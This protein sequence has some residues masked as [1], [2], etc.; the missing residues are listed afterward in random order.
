[1]D[2]NIGGDIVAAMKKEIHRMELRLRELQKKQEELV[3][4]MEKS[5]SRRDVI[6]I[7]SQV[8]HPPDVRFFPPGRLYTSFLPTQRQRTW[9]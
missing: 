7:Q 8:S 2:P 9:K 6:S 3:V 1:M 4:E 5:I